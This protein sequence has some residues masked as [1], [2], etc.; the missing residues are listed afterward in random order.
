MVN[1]PCSFQL[2][3]AINNLD[4]KIKHKIYKTYILEDD[5]IASHYLWNGEEL[6]STWNI[7]NFKKTREERQPT[8][9]D[10]ILINQYE[11]YISKSL[12]KIQLF[13]NSRI[14]TTNLLTLNDI[15]IAALCIILTF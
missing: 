10:C 15:F 4:Q 6:I 5:K 7:S 1:L 8:D 13:N 14:N 3:E 9:Y 11:N 2:Q 12:R